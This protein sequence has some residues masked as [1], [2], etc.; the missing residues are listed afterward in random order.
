[1]STNEQGFERT[2]LR[3]A[4]N[5]RSAFAFL[6]ADYG[7]VLETASVTLVRY[8][9]ADGR[10]VN[11][12]HGRQ[13]YALNFE[14]G[15]TD[16]ERIYA[17]DVAGSAGVP[18]D[19]FEASTP[20][21]VKSSL[22]RLSRLLRESAKDALSGDPLAYQALRSEQARHSDELQRGWALADARARVD[23]AWRA[24]D[25][26]SVVAAFSPLEE[27]LTP[28]ERKKLAMA[29]ERSD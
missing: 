20:E 13:S 25:F 5:A 15:R 22:V 26:R 29:R 4:E 7:F 27:Y 1:M 23:A 16:D 10:Y 17:A 6:E 19:V 24:K 14:L 21:A 8:R 2:A 18:L 3:F 11:V 28:A 9:H 12:F